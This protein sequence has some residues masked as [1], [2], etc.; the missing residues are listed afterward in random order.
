MKCPKCGKE[1]MQGFLQTGNLVAFNKKRHKIS[2]TPK[3]KDDVMIAQSV[4]TAS[5]FNGWICKE[6]GLV[7]F[8]YTNVITH[9]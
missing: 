3:D 7:T 9:W 5:D 6:C 4:F 2:I 8:D 1:M